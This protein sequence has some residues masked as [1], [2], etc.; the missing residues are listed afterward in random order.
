[1]KL[2]LEKLEGWG[3]LYGENCMI[4]ASAIWDIGGL[5]A[6]NHQFCLPWPWNP[7]QGSFWYQ[8]KARVHIPFSDQYQL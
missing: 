8:W 7:G 5:K 1:M 4:L 3:L 2:A 6:E